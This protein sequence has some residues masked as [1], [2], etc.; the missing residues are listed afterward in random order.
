MLSVKTIETRIVALLPFENTV[1][2]ERGERERTP[3]PSS[4]SHLTRRR[5]TSEALEDYAHTALLINLQLT[6]LISTPLVTG[7]R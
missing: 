5:L 2:F 4:P 7:D 6:K 1:L 3:S